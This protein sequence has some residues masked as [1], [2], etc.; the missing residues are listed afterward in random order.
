MRRAD[1]SENYKGDRHTNRQSDH[2]ELHGTNINV[3]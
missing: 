3:G 2:A 1:R